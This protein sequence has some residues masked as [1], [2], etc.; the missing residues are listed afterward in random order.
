MHSIQIIFGQTQCLAIPQG[1]YNQYMLF[2]EKRSSPTR[3]QYSLPKYPSSHEFQTKR[4]R[5]EQGN[6]NGEG[7]TKRPRIGGQNTPQGAHVYERPYGNGPAGMPP[8]E[9]S[10]SSSTQ[11]TTAN[12]RGGPPQPRRAPGQDPAGFV[13]GGGLPPHH[14]GNGL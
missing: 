8:R 2:F 3:A 4:R 7:P 11:Q 6:N 14:H 5:Q 10:S 9:S 1:S 12:W 13:A